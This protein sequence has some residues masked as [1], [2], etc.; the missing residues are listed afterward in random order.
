[1]L[2]SK[3]YIT[4]TGTE[5]YENRIEKNIGF[6]YVYRYWNP[7]LLYL[8]SCETIEPNQNQDGKK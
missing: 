7:C 4:N 5:G 6:N 2:I 1:M 8:G 3:Q